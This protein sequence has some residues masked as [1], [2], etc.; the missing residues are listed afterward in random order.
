MA[1]VVLTSGWEQHIEGAA[2]DFLEKI[3]GEVEDDAKAICPVDTGKLR[4]SIEHEVDGMT[5]R[6]GSNVSYALY[7]EEGT[8][9]HIIRAKNGGALFW[10]GADHPVAVVHHP[11]TRAEP[12]L[13]PA[14]Y[15]ARAS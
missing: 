12:Y 1:R 5:A 2:A 8:S 4:E 10:P 15:R 9:P 3:A 13:K 11:G 14:L 7:V 6:I